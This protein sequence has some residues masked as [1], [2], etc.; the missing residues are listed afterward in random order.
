MP[1]VMILIDF[2]EHPERMT[3]ALLLLVFAV[4]GL[5]ALFAVAYPFVWL[6]DVVDRRAKR[7]RFGPHPGQSERRRL[8]A[9][10]GERCLCGGT[11]VVRRRRADGVRFLG[12]GNFPDCRETRL[13][14]AARIGRPPKA[15]A[16]HGPAKRHGE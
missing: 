9:R 10:A 3:E 14:A 12:C 6:A 16:G 1:F 2:A 8:E 5:L 4:G 11:F 7:K 13:L 15:S